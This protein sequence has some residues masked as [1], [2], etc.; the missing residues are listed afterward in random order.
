MKEAIIFDMGG[1]FIYLK[2]QNEVFWKQLAAQCS[3]TINELQKTGTAAVIKVFAQVR[4][5]N[6]G[7]T[8]TLFVKE[9]AEFLIKTFNNNSSLS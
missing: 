6:S 8:V 5:K 1:V 7:D 3:F 2:P 4:V 9:G